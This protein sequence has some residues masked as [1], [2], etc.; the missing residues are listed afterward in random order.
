M[1]SEPLKNVGHEA[2]AQNVAAGMGIADAYA[3]AGY[4]PN[5]AAATKVGK[6]SEV[7]I[8]IAALQ[9]LTAR[10]AAFTVQDMI[11]QLDEDRKFAK[12]RGAPAAMISASMGKAKILG[13]LVDKQEITGKDGGAIETRDLSDAPDSVVKWLASQPKKG[14]KPSVN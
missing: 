2:F 10:N 9:T 12:E 6:R 4:K 13:M 11:K 3:K 5:A 8:R 14:E 7:A 1:K